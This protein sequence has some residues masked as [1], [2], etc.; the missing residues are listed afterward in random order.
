RILP[1]SADG[2]GTDAVT[3]VMIESG[4]AAGQ[5]WRTLGVSANIIDASVRALAD[6]LTYKLMRDGVTPAAR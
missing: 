2:D 4:A 6:S 1:P 5:V 3:R